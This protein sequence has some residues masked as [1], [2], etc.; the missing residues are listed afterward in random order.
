MF[1]P[2]RASAQQIIPAGRAIKPPAPEF[3]RWPSPHRSAQVARF[4]GGF[5]QVPDGRGLSGFLFV[6]VVFRLLIVEFGVCQF[7]RVA[8]SMSP[9]SSSSLFARSFASISFLAPS[10][11]HP[12]AVLSAPRRDSIRCRILRAS[13]RSASFS[14]RSAAI[15][16]ALWSQVEQSPVVMPVRPLRFQ[17]CRTRRSFRQSPC[18]AR[19]TLLA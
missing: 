12:L 4:R 6:L 1:F 19:A 10:H 5:E 13:Q 18:A 3:S 9:A 7:A 16:F 2:L 11:T 8:S 14:A 15:V 17:S